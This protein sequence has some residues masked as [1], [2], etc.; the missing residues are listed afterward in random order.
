MNLLKLVLK[1]SLSVQFLKFL[2]S[3]LLLIIVG[4]S[5]HRVM[6]K[7][8][9]LINDIPDFKTG[10]YTV[11]DMVDGKK[12]VEPGNSFLGR[13]V[14]LNKDFFYLDKTYFTGIR[15]SFLP[16]FFI[17]TRL[18]NGQFDFY[19]EKSGK[20]DFQ[21]KISFDQITAERIILNIATLSG[22]EEKVVLIYTSSRILPK[23]VNTVFISNSV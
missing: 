17:K 12:S 4:C 8:P 18:V 1:F 15:G 16:D 22:R 6:M 13:M 5:G 2:T 11:S 7:P 21:G 19:W 10:F 14:F 9:E 3:L 23:E 20:E